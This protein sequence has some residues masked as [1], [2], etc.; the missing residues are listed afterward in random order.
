MQDDVERVARALCAA[1]FH[2]D[3]AAISW[4]KAGEWGDHDKWIKQARAAMAATR[5]IDEEALRAEAQ[6]IETLRAGGERAQIVAWLRK[7]AIMSTDSVRRRMNKALDQIEAGAH[8][9]PRGEGGE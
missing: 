1:S 2:P 5:E 9:S 6:E 4:Q 7:E 8:L 3:D